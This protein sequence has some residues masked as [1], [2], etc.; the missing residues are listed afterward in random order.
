MLSQL[1]TTPEMRTTEWMTATLDENPEF[2]Q[3]LN[4]LFAGY[5]QFNIERGAQIDTQTA[6]MLGQVALMFGLYGYKM[7][8][9]QLEVNSMEDETPAEV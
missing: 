4:N 8:Q 9:N 7:V 2:M 6:Q 3:G 1:Q 5:I